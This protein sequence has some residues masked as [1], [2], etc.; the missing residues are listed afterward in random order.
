MKKYFWLL[1]LILTAL[2]SACSS[3][4][5][6][7]GRFIAP[8]GLTSYQ[9]LPDGKVNINKGGED[10]G[11]AQYRYDSDDQ[12]ITIVGADDL[13]ANILTVN[14]EGD[15]EVGDITL[16]RGIDYGMLADSTWMGEQG[17]FV[18]ILTF[19]PAEDGLETVSEL[20][21]YYDDDMTYSSQ[22]D[23]SITRLSGNMMFVDMTQYAVSEVT[24]D[25]FKISIGGNSMTIEKHPKNTG[26]VYREGYHSIDEI[27]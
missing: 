16:T 8:D 14:A 20:V 18:F 23:D 15:L 24:Q 17:E 9:F 19:T 2:L 25:S 1:A 3:N 27:D 4:D 13:P 6:F 10:I 12:A 5:E 21:T 11:T 7:E 26:I 22:I